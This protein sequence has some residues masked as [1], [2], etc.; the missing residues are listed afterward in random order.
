MFFVAVAVVIVMVGGVTLNVLYAP[1]TDTA[2]TASNSTAVY[3]IINATALSTNFTTFTLTA[4]DTA[5]VAVGTVTWSPF[6]SDYL[7]V[8]SVTGTVLG[9]RITTSPA[10]FNIT[11]AL[12]KTAFTLNYSSNGTAIQHSPN[13]TSVSIAYSILPQSTQQGWNSGVVTF[14]NVLLGIVIIA[15]VLLFVVGKAA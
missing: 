13:V 1:T 14:W 10:T 2:G 9:S 11:A 4:P 15:A 6:G 7:N 12:L 3:G 5:V 8:T